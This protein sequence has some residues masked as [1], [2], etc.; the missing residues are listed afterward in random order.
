MD[1]RLIR[2]VCTQL[3]QNADPLKGGA[4]QAYM[5]S[6]M[7]SRGVQPPVRRRLLREIFKECPLRSLVELR[8]IS[9]PLR[10]RACCRDVR[11]AEVGL[12]GIPLYER[13]L[14]FRAPPIC[15]EMIVTG[16]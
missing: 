13:H 2:A 11:C 7:P 1:H 16:A 6:A 5:K 9:L 14:T 4:M 8:E 3:A 15:E 10:R 12:I